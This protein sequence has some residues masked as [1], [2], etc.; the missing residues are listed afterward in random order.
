M[1]L[2]FIASEFR[3]QLPR[4][5]DPLPNGTWALPPH[6]N[7]LNKEEPTRYVKYPS[8]SVYLIF[9]HMFQHIL[10][11][12]SWKSAITWLI[13]KRVR[14]PSENRNTVKW[15]RNGR[16]FSKSISSTALGKKKT[17]LWNKRHM[18][19]GWY[20]KFPRLACFLFADRPNFWEH[21][22]S[23][24]LA[25]RTVKGIR[26]FCLNDDQ[27]SPASKRRGSVNIIQLFL[28]SVVFSSFFVVSL[29]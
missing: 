29:F 24:G 8:W 12:Q 26:T 20:Y 6:M 27:A 1:K 16:L 5:F 18:E 15:R 28:Y 3:G 13:W 2:L 21:S 4:P 17:K 23:R 9:M 7:D 14:L 11:R 22:T 10:C 19:T 25:R